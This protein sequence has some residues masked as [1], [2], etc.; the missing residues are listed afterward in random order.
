MF[1]LSAALPTY[2]PATTKSVGGIFVAF[3]LCILVYTLL[4]LG[5]EVGRL[6]EV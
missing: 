3:R 6:K 5:R 4:N 1:F 2:A